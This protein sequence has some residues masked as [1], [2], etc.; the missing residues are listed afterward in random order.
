MTALGL[1]ASSLVRLACLRS[2]ASS[3]SCHSKPQETLYQV[4]QWHVSVVALC[5]LD[6]YCYLITIPMFPYIHV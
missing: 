3:T 4:V 6:V 2:L 1:L 5:F